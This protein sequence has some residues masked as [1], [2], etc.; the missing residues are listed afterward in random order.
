M[1]VLKSNFGGFKIDE[2]YIGLVAGLFKKSR[3]GEISFRDDVSFITWNY[4]LQVEFA[5]A[6]FKYMN[7]EKLQISNLLFELGSYPNQELNK[8]NQRIIHLN[9][10][11]GYRRIKVN[12]SEVDNTIPDYILVDQIDFRQTNFQ[13][14]CIQELYTLSMNRSSCDIHFSWDSE[15][16]NSSAVKIAQRI[17]EQSKIIVIIGYSFPFFNREVDRQLL[18]KEVLSNCDKIYVQDPKFD[19][20]SFIEQFGLNDFSERIIEVGNKPNGLLS[21]FIPPEM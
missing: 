19:K 11:S 13:E 9:G 4:D 15:S 2:R 8:E 3:L 5:H 20:D 12:K 1:G 16:I 21:F 14:Y 6:L 18:D 10:T 7:W 17:L